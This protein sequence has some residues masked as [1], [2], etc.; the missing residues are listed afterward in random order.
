MADWGLAGRRQTKPLALMME[1]YQTIQGLMK[2]M[3]VWMP[4]EVS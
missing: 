1:S 3:E 4:S 2:L